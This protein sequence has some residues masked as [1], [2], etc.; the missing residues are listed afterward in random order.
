[1]K[2][3]FEFFV[4]VLFLSRSDIP[5]MAVMVF[6]VRLEAMRRAVAG[7]TRELPAG[8][9]DMESLY[10]LWDLALP[11]ENLPS[12]WTSVRLSPQQSVEFG[13]L[14][15]M[16]N[17]LFGVN[18]SQV[19]SLALALISQIQMEYTSVFAQFPTLDGFEVWL[20]AKYL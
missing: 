5:D 18:R 12:N 14:Q 8:I 9:R 20:K 13:R 4:A 16:L 19:F 1:M 11:D 17:A 6:S 15:G 3:F 2:R 7:R 10:L